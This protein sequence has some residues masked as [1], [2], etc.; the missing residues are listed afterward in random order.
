M[1]LRYFGPQSDGALT[2]VGEMGIAKVRVVNKY[3]HLGCVIHHRSDNRDEARRRIGI[4]QQAFTQHRR[5]LLCNPDLSLQRRKF[6]FLVT[7]VLL[8]NQ[9]FGF[10]LAKVQLVMLG[11][12]IQCHDCCLESSLLSKVTS[13]S[14]PNRMITI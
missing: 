12:S 2:I 4:A 8:C 13:L 9:G 1:K 14:Q 3:T 7:R 10:W 11:E 5:H 6:W